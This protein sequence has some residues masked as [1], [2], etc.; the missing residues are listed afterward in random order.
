MFGFG[1][2]G[3]YAERPAYDD[4]I[5]GASTLP[6]LMSR[7]GSVEPRYSPNALADRV[8]GLT[9]VGAILACIINRDRTGR[10]QRIDI[11]M[12]ETMVGFVLAD[13]LGGLSFDPPL[14]QGGYRRQLSSQRKPFKTSDGYVCAV[15]FT[16]AQWD[17]FFDLSNRPD[18][19]S[20]RRFS[21][22]GLRTENVDLLYAELER[23]F[24]SRSSAEWLRL[25]AEADIPAMP[26]HDI[27]G[28]LKDEH[29]QAVGFFRT[30]DHPTEGRVR[31]MRVPA[32]WSEGLL[33]SSRLAPR[34]G[35]HSR[36][37][38]SEAGFSEEAIDWLV[39]NGVTADSN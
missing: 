36:E 8:V 29:L 15:I 10:G 24:V 28:V 34:L 37:I 12:F 3:P 18:L 16:D 4:L 33:Q 5:Q 17:R 6:F 30:V 19:K 9:A 27:V 14:D 23:I 32:S 31:T 35:E 7:S 13:H 25:L 38:L 20:D 22:I 11:P 2:D 39:R 21:N 1:Q 26:M